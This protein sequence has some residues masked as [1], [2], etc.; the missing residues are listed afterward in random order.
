[1]HTTRNTLFSLGLIL[2]ITLGITSCSNQPKNEGQSSKAQQALGSGTLRVVTWNVEHLAFPITDGCRPRT[3][4]E[5]RALR[6]Y[7]QDLEAD[8]VALQEVGSIAA[9]G[10]VFPPS[11]WQ[12]FLS[13]RPDSETYE[14]RESGRQS[15]QQK[16]AFAVQNDIEVLGETDFTAL[17]LDNPGLRHGMEL[18]VSTPLGEMDILNVHMKSGCFED[19][20]SRSDSEAC[21]TF[22]R[23]A[24]VLDDWIEAKEREKTPY[25][26]VGDFNHRLSSPYNK[27]SMLMAD[28]SNGAKSNLV[29]A[30]AS[31]IGCHPYY[32][33]PIDHILMGQL[34]SPALISSPR[35]HSYDDMNPD[36]MLSDHCAVSLTLEN[37]QLPLSTSVTWQTTSKEYR[38]L[39]T[40]T[41][42]RASEYLKG[43]SLPTTPWMVTM[44][45]DETVMD[46]SDYQVMLDRSGRTYTSESWA[47]WVASDEARLV[48]GVGSFIETVIGLGGH[49]GFITNRNRVQD[50]HTWSNMLALGLPLTT[51]NSCLMGR[52]SKDVSSVNGGSIIND[53]DLRREQLENGTSSCYQAENERHNSFPGATIVMQVGDNIED[54]AG[55]TQETASLEALLASTETTYILLPNPMYGSW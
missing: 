35:V 24:P 22:A 21:Q 41:Y 36:N 17:G 2:A 19:D 29:N 40:S 51:T 23:Q 49:V 45:I 20:F 15:T 55:V 18:T 48:P 11:D 28:N 54:F 50:H 4:A 1:M 38:Y 8:I 43:A 14:C 3:K 46:N 42:H 39:T 27:L 31:L 30:T 26:V 47:K 44:D 33:A 6:S 53:K 32:P 9:L 16:V 34:Q 25:L 37:G 5:I 52:S 10:Q 7:A 12:L 13:Q